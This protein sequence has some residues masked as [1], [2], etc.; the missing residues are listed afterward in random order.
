[1]PVA[2]R[3]PET[4]QTEAERRAMLKRVPVDVAAKIVI[5]RD[6]GAI[7]VVNLSAGGILAKVDLMLE[8]GESVIVYLK[9]MMPL[10]AL[11]RWARRDKV[12]IRFSQPLN[13]HQLRLLCGPVSA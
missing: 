12:G 9:G 7:T 5:G 10:P 11:V 4:T 3:R 2:A 6:E 8:P 1:M 13:A